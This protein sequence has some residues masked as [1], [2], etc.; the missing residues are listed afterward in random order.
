M[1]KSLWILDYSFSVVVQSEN[2]EIGCWV[3]CFYTTCTL[4]CSK[5]A[6]ELPI[7]TVMSEVNGYY[8]NMIFS[9]TYLQQV[10][11]GA[12]HIQTS[13]WLKQMT[14]K[15][16]LKGE[17]RNPSSDAPKSRQWETAKTAIYQQPWKSIQSGHL[18]LELTISKLLSS[19]WF[20]FLL[21]ELLMNEMILS[22]KCR[23]VLSDGDQP[24]SIA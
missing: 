4:E 11:P 24:R 10:T 18:I 12:V 20:F 22:T 2:S 7:L 19:K 6:A 21:Q 8:V 16:N 1:T 3:S 13:S 14:T 5:T 23:R 9:P 15:P 17:E